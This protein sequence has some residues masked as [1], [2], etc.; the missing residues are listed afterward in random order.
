MDKPRSA[1]RQQYFL[2]DERP[3]ISLKSNALVFFHYLE[4]YPSSIGFS[5]PDYAKEELHIVVAEIFL[6]ILKGKTLHYKLDEHDEFFDQFIVYIDQK[7]YQLT[8]TFAVRFD[9]VYYFLELVYV[10]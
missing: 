7:N 8:A 10:G 2:D 5:A 3:R 6:R 4:T 1:R 9:G